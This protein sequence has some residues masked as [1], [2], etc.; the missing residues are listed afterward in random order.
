MIR[1]KR[2]EGGFMEAIIAFAA[3]TTALTVFLGLLAYSEIGNADSTVGL[4]TEFIENLTIEDGRFTGY[5]DSGLRRFI[6]RNDLNGTELK[7]N[8][9]GHLSDASLDDVIGVTEGNNVG[10]ISGTFSV[11]SDDG[12]TFV[13]SY[14]VIYWWD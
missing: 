14:E 12:R 3:V 5:D 11:H 1:N 4:D 9:A 13:A 2:G 8:V 10:T 6:E 7:V